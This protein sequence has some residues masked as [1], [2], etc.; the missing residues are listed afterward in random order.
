MTLAVWQK[1]IR[2]DE[3]NLLDRIPARLPLGGRA[4]YT[5]AILVVKVTFLLNNSGD[6]IAEQ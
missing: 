4:D 5:R 6:R 1:P 2:K 3:R